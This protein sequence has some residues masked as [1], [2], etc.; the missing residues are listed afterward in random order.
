MKKI[1]RMLAVLAL[2][3]VMATSLNA[4]N[5]LADGIGEDKAGFEIESAQNKGGAAGW[6]AKEEGVFSRSTTIA[7]NGNASMKV[8]I[9]AT[10][11]KLKQ[12]EMTSGI[13]TVEKGKSYKV[14]CWIFIDA[15]KGNR[16]KG[17]QL[18]LCYGK[19]MSSTV[20]KNTVKTGEWVK[21]E[22]TTYTIPA[23]SKGNKFKVNFRAFLNDA[24]KGKLDKEILFYLD[25]VQVEEVK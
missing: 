19:W 24:Y 15:E 1:V 25:D 16:I 21:I 14:S 3:L 7:N 6:T 8:N 2:P 4:Q 18:N 11:L 12:V 23:D 9:P 10:E 20:K 22:S 17:L 13:F 5:L